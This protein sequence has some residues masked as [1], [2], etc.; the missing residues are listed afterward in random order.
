L[1][2][3]AI[4]IVIVTLGVA[5]FLVI[6]E[7]Q[8]PAPISVSPEAELLC[9]E[10]TADTESFKLVSA[11]E[12]LEQALE[13]DPNLAEAAISLA[14][15]QG[16]LGRISDAKASMAMADSLTELIVDDT[17]RMLAQLRLSRDFSS[18]YRVMRDSVLTRLQ[19]LQPDNIYVMVAQAANAA[20]MDDDVEAE[21]I[22]KAILETN[23]NYA[24]SYNLLGYME[25]RRGNFEKAVGYMQKYAFL[26]PNLANPH[27]SLGE[28]Y[29]TMGRYEDA[30]GEFITSIK[31]QP[32]FYHSLI[33]LGNVYMARGQMTKGVELL[34][35]VRTKL[36][37]S[38]LEQRID[39][40]VLHAYLNSGMEKE[41]EAMSRTF[42]ERYPDMG[43]TAFFRAMRLAYQGD[44]PGSQ[45]V[46]DSSLAEWRKGPGYTMDDKHMLNVDST[47]KRY[48]AL[49]SDLAD[50]PATRVRHWNGVVT[51][52]EDKRE[53]RDQVHDRWRLGEALL[54]NDE[55]AKAL[56]QSDL[57]LAY[58][59]RLIN[60][61][62]LHV[63]SHLA[64]KNP[65]Q[66]RQGLEQ[67]KWSLS[68]ADE[69][70]PALIRS[71]E[72]EALVVD[73]ER[74]R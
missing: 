57:M 49:I 29:M 70:F 34:E 39:V 60:F 42:M 56:V 66:A 38:A 2:K 74:A 20:Y 3:T 1:R 52:T 11:V 22:Y 36:A 25:L 68:Q 32:D 10:G 30:E 8:S 37:G 40:Q 62:I 31:M 24:D 18:R 59:P 5:A 64:L 28:V 21:R 69:G 67:L 65:E 73:L 9:K 23:P 51:M 54:A 45:A 53:L 4:G 55:P 58:N 44:L 43:T 46:M 13:L 61:L 33:N 72:L 47:G 48:E 71:R 7:A 35:K 26:A 14:S 12:K 50:S 19:T 41:L 16:T 17:R 15:A 6:S 63:E 27:D